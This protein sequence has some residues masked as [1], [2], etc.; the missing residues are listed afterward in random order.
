MHITYF[1]K[2]SGAW[3]RMISDLFKP[4]DITKWFVVGFTAFLAGL[5]DGPHRGGGS[6]FNLGKKDWSGIAD[7]PFNA[8][9]WLL[10]HPGWFVLIV[11][12]LFVV[13]LLVIVLNWLSS[14]GKFMFLDNV[15]HNRAQVVKPWNEYRKLG[16]SLFLWRLVFG[17]ICLGLMLIF[18]SALFIA[19][20]YLHNSY[21]TALP[22]L[23]IIG[24]VISI[25]ATVITIAYISSF[26]NN[27]VVPIMYKNN[28]P[29]MKG[30]GE[31]LRLFRKNPLHFILFGLLMF[32][33]HVIVILAVVFAG[34]FTCCIGF[35]IL[36]IPYISSVILLPISYTF[37]AFGVTF[38]E[39]FGPE[40]EIFPEKK[41]A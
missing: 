38:L 39:Q 12:G 21:Q 29:V 2:L 41:A 16:N 14:R 35:V 31:F 10:D 25:L 26:L 17:L 13:V 36:A 19:I 4:F 9:N 3:N 20:S 37:R 34:F 24:I 32:V 5:I 40:Y 1:D 23:F 30:W 27:F 15:V 8:W 7:F 11:F 6:K 18:V 28:L 22:I 33:L